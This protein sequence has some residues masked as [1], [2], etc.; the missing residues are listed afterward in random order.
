MHTNLP[1]LFQ[2]WQYFS[3]STG[4]VNSLFFFK[5]G[6]FFPSHIFWLSYVQHDDISRVLGAFCGHVNSV[7]GKLCSISVGT[8]AGTGS[9]WGRMVLSIIPHFFF[10]DLQDIWKFSLH[11]P[12]LTLSGPLSATNPCC[13]SASKILN[14]DG[15][16][17]ALHNCKNSY[18]KGAQ[19][20]QFEFCKGARD[21]E[22][23]SS[24]RTALCY[25]NPNMHTAA[26]KW[27]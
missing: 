23:N 2:R 19:L 8:G 24:V 1:L 6:T 15:G 16:L 20:E 22:Q 17:L 27:E 18:D 10:K 7:F 13:D 4:H 12:T 14:L 9:F 26:L 25:R 11:S 3:F 21:K 5:I